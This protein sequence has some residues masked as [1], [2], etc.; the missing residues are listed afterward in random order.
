MSWNDEEG[1]EGEEG[2]WVTED[3]GSFYEI[4]GH[5]GV[6]VLRVSRDLTEAQMWRAIDAEMKRRGTFGTVWMRSDHGNMVLAGS[7]HFAKKGPRR[8]R[9]SEPKTGH[10]GP[11]PASTGNM[12]RMTKPKRRRAAP[13]ANPK[14][15]AELVR[16]AEQKYGDYGALI[17]GGLRPH[18]PESVKDE[19]RAA[20]H[21]KPKA[22]SRKRR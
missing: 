7:G 17:S 10:F 22:P 2:D 5:R 14:K 15:A 3:G 21:G 4:G 8:T 11:N 12:H 19:I 18:W 6:P 13:G 9:T 20:W 16:A 1:E